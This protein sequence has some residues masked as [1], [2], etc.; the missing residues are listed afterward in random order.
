MAV[1]RKD[2]VTRTAQVAGVL[3]L[4][5]FT[6]MTPS[7]RAGDM[8]IEDRN[9]Y[10]NESVTANTITIRANTQSVTARFFARTVTNE[11]FFEKGT[12]TITSEFREI[13]MRAN[14]TVIRW[15][16]ISPVPNMD[17]ISIEA[18]TFGA[19][20]G[21]TFDP[22]TV[23]L[24]PCLTFA[25]ALRVYGE[26]AYINSPVD[27][28][29][30]GL[31]TF[32]L[33]STIAAG[34]TM[35]RMTGAGSVALDNT[36]PIRLGIS[37]NSPF[38]N[39]VAGDRI[40]LIDKTVGNAA[41]GQYGVSHGVSDYV[42]DVSTV[43]NQLIADYGYRDLS[44]TKQYNLTNMSELLLMEDG[45]NHTMKIIGAGQD[46]FIGEIR[47]GISTSANVDGTKQTAS[48]ACSIDMT[49]YHMLVGLDVVRR[50]GA[51]AYKITGFLDGGWGDY[52]TEDYFTNYAGRRT[53]LRGDGKVRTLGG[54][55][56][57]FYVFENGFGFDAS[58][59]AGEVKSKLERTNFGQ[60][61]TYKTPSTWY[62]DTH[63]G[64]SKTF[65]FS[66]KSYFRAYG[67]YL[68]GRQGQDNFF[69]DANEHLR[70]KG[71]SSS[72]FRAGG[73]YIYKPTS[74]T[75]LFADAAWEYQAD[76]RVR[77]TIDG[78]PIASTLRTNGHMG[79]VNVGASWRQRPVGGWDVSVSGGAF[80][81]IKH[82]FSLSAQI[83]YSF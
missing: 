13:D 70:F 19:G 6:L 29:L 44:K 16:G 76:G 21:L 25:G 81:E 34:A 62:A 14:D 52:Y 54:G 10:T 38:T 31:G 20:R 41:P 45:Q 28:R 55:L 65:E 17:F 82:G 11:I 46:M 32:Y 48:P 83:G 60:N 40:I 75:N 26:N 68:Y 15:A 3:M 12:G 71:T 22:S 49:S 50:A 61:A 47:E 39:L 37:D 57:G 77:H 1:C 9:Y 33:P 63:I 80:Y 8:V 64:L 58:I 78:M 23:N 73:R 27:Y 7:I 56:M 30:E 24:L 51:G 74:R 43:N 79:M 69:T 72:R 5:L 59:R 35:L 2:R 18:L 4:F 53:K 67:K 42:F 66:P 36:T